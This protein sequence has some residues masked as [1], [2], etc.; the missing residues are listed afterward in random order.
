MKIGI[1]GSGHIGGTL[2]KLFAGAG[3]EV[4]M[5]SRH[6]EQLKEHAAEIGASIG[7][8]ADAAAF[9]EV[10]VF[11]VPWG[12]KEQAAELTGPVNGK[13]VIDTTNP[14]GPN[15]PMDLGD[16]TSSEIVARLLPGARTVKA[17]NTI[18]YSDLQTQG[19]SDSEGRRAIPLASD[20][21]DAK[22]QIA[23]LIAEIGFDPVDTGSL[24][25]GGRK[26]QP[27]A[28]IYNNNLTADDVKALL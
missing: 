1:V 4:T 8:I 18:T 25:D 2:A 26:Q 14:Y 3:H 20:D 27:D 28:P 5:S 15:G 17:F 9:G 11:S 19:K 16:D 24:R 6:P 10:V 12:T 7:S 13:I 23:Q 22:A 21:A